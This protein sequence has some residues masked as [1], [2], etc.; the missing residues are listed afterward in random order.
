[1]IYLGSVF[2]SSGE[3]ATG[4]EMIQDL[5]SSFKVAGPAV[6]VDANIVRASRPNVLVVSDAG[7]PAARSDRLRVLDLSSIS[8]AANKG[9][10]SR[11]RKSR[12]RPT[13]SRSKA[14][15]LMSPPGHRARKWWSLPGLL[16]L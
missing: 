10:L 13:T 2:A 4:L 1:M 15:T 6:L 14:S 7:G 11:L 12:G 16:V 9:S 3:P 5:G 8:D